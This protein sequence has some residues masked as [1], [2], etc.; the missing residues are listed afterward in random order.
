MKKVGSRAWRKDSSGQTQVE[1]ALTIIFVL[2]LIFG[3]IELVLY[4]YTYSVMADSAKEGVR[5]AIVHGVNASAPSGPTCPCP[6][7]DG[8]PGTG[9]VKTYA[10][11]SFHDTSAMT[12]NVVYNPDTDAVCPTPFN[13]APCAV[14]V[15]VS[16]PYSP[17]LGFGGPTVTLNAAAEGRIVF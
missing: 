17:L 16:Y 1:F 2:F 8:A 3:L 10:Q 9:V 12:V 14:R 4:I 7:I 5:Y 6:A 11:F 15:T 13:S